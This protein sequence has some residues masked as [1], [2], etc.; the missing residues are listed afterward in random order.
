MHTNTAGPLT[1]GGRR[2]ADLGRYVR[3]ESR[4]DRGAP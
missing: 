4:V 3:I 2:T 1:P